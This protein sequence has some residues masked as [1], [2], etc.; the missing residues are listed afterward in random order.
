MTFL[1][2]SNADSV[3]ED[4]GIRKDWF[5]NLDFFPNSS[6]TESKP[7]LKLKAILGALGPPIMGP[8]ISH[9]LPPVGNLNLSPIQFLNAGTASQHMIRSQT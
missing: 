5:G 4:I 1:T 2:K 7:E 3:F 6:G 8:Q 9:R